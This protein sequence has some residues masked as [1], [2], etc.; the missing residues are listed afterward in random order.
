M[1]TFYSKI[2]AWEALFMFMLYSHNLQR[3]LHTFGCQDQTHDRSVKRSTSCHRAASTFPFS[4]NFLP[5]FFS[6]SKNISS[7][8]WGQVAASSLASIRL[9]TPMSSSAAAANFNPT[10]TCPKDI[11]RSSYSRCELIKTSCVGKKSFYEDRKPSLFKASLAKSS[12]AP[13]SK[14]QHSMAQHSRA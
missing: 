1:Q 11:C 5:R 8:Y 14:A 7:F 10:Y 3:Y 12:V 9:N 2:I 13:S 4:W 6:L